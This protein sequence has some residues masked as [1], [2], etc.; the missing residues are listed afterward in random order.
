MND[1]QTIPPWR[2]VPLLAQPPAD[3]TEAVPN[4]RVACAK[5]APQPGASDYKT[6]VQ[7]CDTVLGRDMS[8][9]NDL[10]IGV[11]I[12]LCV[13]GIALFLV[14]LARDLRRYLRSRMEHS[15]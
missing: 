10:A 1:N 14:A 7:A 5:W 15:A 9:P 13:V 6:E 12:T 11:M 3:V 2:P 8:F 4:L